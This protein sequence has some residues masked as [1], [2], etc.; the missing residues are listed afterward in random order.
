MEHNLR[1]NGEPN[2]HIVLLILITSR[3]KQR[4]RKKL[5]FESEACEEFIRKNVY[6][7]SSAPLG[8]TTND[9]SSHPLVYSANRSSS[10]TRYLSDLGSPYCKKFECITTVKSKVKILRTRLSCERFTYHF[11]ERFGKAKTLS[12]LFISDSQV[13]SSKTTVN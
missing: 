2:F 13:E 12:Q 5:V 11:Y 4:C 8:D 7:C 1:Q 3:S 9:Q 10:A 6:L